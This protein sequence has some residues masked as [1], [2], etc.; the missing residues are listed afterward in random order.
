MRGHTT[1]A[2]RPDLTSSATRCQVRSTQ[3]GLSVGTTW[4][5][6]GARPRGSSVSVDVS[7]SPNTVIVTVRGIGVAV[8]TRTC[9]GC[10]ALSRKASRCS[11]PNRCCSST[12]TSARSK[13]WTCSWMRACVPMTMPASP[14]AT[15][16]SERLRAAA[17]WLPVSRATRVPIS[18][19]PSMPPSASSPSIAVIERKCCAA[20]TSVGASNAAWP[21]A[22]TAASMARRAMTVLPDPTSPCR[23]RFIGVSPAISRASVAPT[24]RCPAVSSKG[25]RAS[26]ASSSPPGP[27]VRATAVCSRAR[28]ARR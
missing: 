5:V 14:L 25:S 15:S 27:G 21:P 22:S 20:R 4:V 17:D 23:R 1:Y 8:I 3:R 10:F 11:T 7:M 28:R 24:S 18:L 13:N 6:I 26:K 12:T 2:W 16:S 19:P 9:G